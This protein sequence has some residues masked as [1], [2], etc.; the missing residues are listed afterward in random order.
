MIKFRGREYVR[1]DG[2][3]C[4]AKTGSRTYLATDSRDDM[5]DTLKRLQQNESPTLDRNLLLAIRSVAGNDYYAAGSVS[6]VAR[7]IDEAAS[8]V[9]KFFA[10][11]D[12]TGP[13][14]FPNSEETASIRKRLKNFSDQLSDALRA[15]SKAEYW[16][17]VLLLDS[18]AATIRVSSVFADKD[19]AHQFA[20]AL[21]DLKL[22]LGDVETMPFWRALAAANRAALGER[23][24]RDA[25]KFQS[26]L[27]SSVKL[28][29][30]GK[31]VRLQTQIE[32]AAIDRLINQVQRASK[33]ASVRTPGYGYERFPWPPEKAAPLP[34]K[35]A[36]KPSETA[37]AMDWRKTAERK[38]AEEKM[39]AEEKAAADAVAAKDKRIAEEEAG[40]ERIRRARREP[41]PK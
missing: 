16:S 22:N 7:S 36:E 21:G 33:G 19:D 15:L 18:S 25:L 30:R 39:A 4:V 31:E 41:E 35:P 9:E 28:S 5:E 8:H 23:A 26:E 14:L 34:E 3:R 1:L 29:E 13:G 10:A 32:V 11:F 17:A 12:S 6:A 24:L 2:G 38:A 40:A 37:A 27:L 20:V